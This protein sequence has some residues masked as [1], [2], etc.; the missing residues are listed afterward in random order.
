MS[1]PF[2]NKTE[3]KL[4]K[5]EIAKT[6]I[7]T[8]S[9]IAIIRIILILI[10]IFLMLIT[11]FI[12]SIG[13]Y[14]KEEKLSKCGKIFFTINQFF[15]NIIKNIKKLCSKNQISNKTNFHEMSRLRRCLLYVVQIYARCIMFCLGYWY[16]S[17]KFPENKNCIVFPSYME[18]NNSAKIC[19]ANHVS[20]VDSL[21]FLSRC[22]PRSIVIQANMALPFN[23]ALNAFSPILVPQTDKQRKKL[24]STKELI[25]EN[26]ESTILKRPLI[27]FPEGGTT[28]SNSLIKFQ[29]GAFNELQPVQP[30]ALKYTYNNFDP[31]W[32]NDI[33]PVWLLYRMCCQFTNYLSVEYYEIISPD[34]TNNIQTNNNTIIEIKDNQSKIEQEKNTECKQNS[35]NIILNNISNNIVSE[36]KNKVYNRFLQ[37]PFFVRTSYSLSDSRITSKLYKNKKIPIEYI[38]EI[39]LYGKNGVS[40]IC[41]DCKI[42]RTDLEKIIIKFYKYNKKNTYLNINEF[43]E[44]MGKPILFDANKLF[45]LIKISPNQINSFNYVSF[46]EIIAL[47]KNDVSIC[48]YQSTDNIHNI[49]LTHILS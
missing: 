32:T 31:S 12:T 22:V 19:L 5:K 13:Y 45:D 8:I 33:S 44:F 16:I 29:D 26:I 20:F 6:I 36:F 42:K 23:W 10:L 21:Y 3:N 25:H 17:E 2:I 34:L 4:T 38:N 46:N 37:D 27:I 39:I 24:K 40:K 41:N 18:R 9:G 48:F 15:S 7:M 49:I 43:N 28:Q 1:N 30:I 11:L 14:S 35:E 47:L